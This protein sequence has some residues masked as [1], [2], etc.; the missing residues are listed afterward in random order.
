VKAEIVTGQPAE[1]LLAAAHKHN[2]D[3]IAVG[4]HRKGFVERVLVGNTAAKLLRTA[5]CSVLVI[6]QH[7]ETAPTRQG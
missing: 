1:Q 2:A 3:L 6:P 7:P 4:W 5:T